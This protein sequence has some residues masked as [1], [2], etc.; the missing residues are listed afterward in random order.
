MKR[1]WARTLGNPMGQQLTDIVFVALRA[2]WSGERG[3]RNKNGS[4]IEYVSF[5]A[6][7]CSA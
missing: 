5:Y 7:F 3:S 2:V 4:H 1:K 6:N